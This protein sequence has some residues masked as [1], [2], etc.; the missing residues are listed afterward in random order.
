MGFLSVKDEKAA[1]KMIKPIVNI[2]KVIDIY[3][4]VVVGLEGVICAGSSVKVDAVNALINIKK[5]GKNIVL[6]TSSAKRVAE[7]AELLQKNKLPHL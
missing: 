3:D 5:A 1:M 7:I 6:L 2:S 4:T